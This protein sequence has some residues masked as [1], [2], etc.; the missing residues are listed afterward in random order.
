MVAGRLALAIPSNTVARFLASGA[1]TGWL[2]VSLLPVRVPRRSEFAFGLVVMEVQPGSPAERSSLLPG[3]ILLGT[4]EA[5]FTSPGDLA[6][7]LESCGEEVLRLEFLRGD[8]TRVRKVSV[9]LGKQRREGS[10][11]A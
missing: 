1:E 7:R 2:G 11:A 5:P 9:Q 3:D 6:G 10:L 4:K 8:Y